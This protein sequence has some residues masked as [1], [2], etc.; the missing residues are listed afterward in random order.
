LQKRRTGEAGGGRY[1]PAIVIDV[2]ENFARKVVVVDEEGS[3]V[4]KA[5]IKS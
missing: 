5:S 2:G 4:Y 1:R 3:L